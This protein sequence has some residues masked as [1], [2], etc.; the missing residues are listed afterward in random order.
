MHAIRVA[1]AA[2]LG[3]GALA[4]ALALAAAPGAVAVDGAATPF[5]FGLRPALVEPGDLITLRVDRTDGECEGRATVS[6]PVL[7][8][9]T[10]PKNR[11]KATT[12]VYRDARPGAVHQ[13]AFTCDGGTGTTSL[14]IAGGRPVPL[15]SPL[16]VES[17]GSAGHPRGAHAGEGGGPPGS[18]LSDIAAGH[19]PSEDLRSATPR[20]AYRS[21]PGHPFTLAPSPVV[22]TAFSVSAMRE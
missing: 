18:V 11:S 21:P 2:L 16:P 1:S 4:L 20:M 22:C 15:P 3:V 17:E 7:G 9:V 13:V 19:G 5:G 10:I 12:E 8:T 14:T 6:S